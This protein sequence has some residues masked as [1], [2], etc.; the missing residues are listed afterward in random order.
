[1]F[2]EHIEQSKKE[3]V[4]KNLM[5]NN[6]ITLRK[7]QKKEK[8]INKLKDSNILSFS[9]LEK[10]YLILSSSFK[11]PHD[12]KE[13]WNKDGNKILILRKCLI[14]DDEI[15]SKYSINN[16]LNNINNDNDIQSIKFLKNIFD[17]NIINKLILLLKEF[18]NLFNEK[19]YDNKFFLINDSNISNNNCVSYNEIEMIIYNIC[20]I[21]IRLTV[22]STD[23]SFL[24]M[25]NDE[26]IQLI[27]F[28]LKY[29]VRKN[30]YISTNL[31]IIIYNLYLDDK[32]T[33][34]NKCDKLIP[35]I[36]E[37]L[38]NYQNNPIE[39]I[40]QIDFLFN[41]LE[42]LSLLTIEKTLY[43]NNS[44]INK[45]IP[46]MINIYENY[47]N[48][49][50]KISSLK[51]L[52]N[53]FHLVNEGSEL[54]INELGEFIKSL[55]KNL[56]IELNLPFV[57]IK[58]LE[59]ISFISYLYEIEEFS[60]DELLNEIN[61]LLISLVSHKE[62]IQMY[63]NN[64]QI[65][66]I[67]ENIS[68]LLL[69]FCLSS[70]DCEYIIQNTTIIKS[71]ILIL[72]NYSIELH[73]VK[74]LYNFLNEF[75]DNIDNFIY[76]VLCNFLEIGILKNLE[77]YSLNKN[78]EI[79]LIIL[80]LTYK[81]LDYGKIDKNSNNESDIN[82]NFVQSFFEKKGFNDKLNIIISPDFGNMECI[83]L[84]KKIQEDFFS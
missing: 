7:M 54:K 76:L 21:L 14:N 28:T 12:F 20:K 51:C 77:K 27:F 9:S 56:N 5:E 44:D 82:I 81:A 50:I 19:K 47:A 39:N 60:S 67:I 2:I 49:S 83:Y 33:I 15:V 43:L 61:H 42:F 16:E 78:Y 22:I 35:F 34:L 31:L 45:I 55:L 25:Q 10:N 30:Q 53:L 68:I 3:N 1:M 41:L 52:S 72:Y 29:F 66:S 84:A 71:V 17:A 80:N 37:N 64:N 18:T 36:I 65:N 79:I 23:F 40:I 62:N 4:V 11:L 58:T 46:L 69:N 75:M 13:Y 70:K 59:I 32:N 24:I 74:N 63:Y 8:S 57:V 6:V 26:N 48:D 38:Y 73:I